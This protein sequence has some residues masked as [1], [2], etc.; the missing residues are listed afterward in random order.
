MQRGRISFQLWVIFIQAPFRSKMH[1]QSED[2]TPGLLHTD[3]NKAA[4]SFFIGSEWI[5]G[6]KIQALP[7]LLKTTETDNSKNA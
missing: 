4:N 1:Q 2:E 6:K 3:A 5:V 7:L